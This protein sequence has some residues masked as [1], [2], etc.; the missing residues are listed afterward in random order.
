MV[1][2]NHYLDYFS[3]IDIDI[4]ECDLEELEWEN[5]EVAII[6]FNEHIEPFII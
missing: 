3:H 4:I 2:E 5:Y 1:D 6:P